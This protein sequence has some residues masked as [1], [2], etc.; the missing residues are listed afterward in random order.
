MSELWQ[1]RVPEQ[2]LK[3]KPYYIGLAPWPH[4]ISGFG[5]DAM[6]RFPNPDIAPFMF[7][8]AA[9]EL[10]G[11]SEK[12]LRIMKALA[13]DETTLTISNHA[14][15]GLTYFKIIQIVEEGFALY[16][17]GSLRWAKEARLREIHED[18][19]CYYDNKN[20][21]FLDYPSRKDGDK[22]AFPLTLGG[23]C[24]WQRGNGDVVDIAKV[25][26][27][28]PSEPFLDHVAR[29]VRRVARVMGNF[30]AGETL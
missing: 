6:N 18:K 13:P 29:R 15:C 22:V 9:D 5:T 4:M 21:V 24:L 17:F 26:T 30:L 27:P 23:V 2:V 8:S 16:D 10:V 20:A 12:R 28:A 25:R 11:T 14:S 7:A 1:K 3:T 19:S